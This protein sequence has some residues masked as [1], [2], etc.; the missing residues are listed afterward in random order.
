L[1]SDLSVVA[2][3]LV[4]AL[5]TDLPLVDGLSAGAGLADAAVS[6]DF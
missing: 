3:P 1:V 5:S 2:F 6:A 4:S